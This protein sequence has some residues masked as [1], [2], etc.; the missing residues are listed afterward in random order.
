MKVPVKIFVPC[1]R[2]SF[3]HAVKIGKKL[4]NCGCSV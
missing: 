4:S 1:S 3:I 2:I